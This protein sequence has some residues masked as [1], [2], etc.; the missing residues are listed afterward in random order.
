MVSLQVADQGQDLLLGGDVERGGGLVRD[1]EFR[2]Q[3]QRH[4]DHDALALAA[5][6]PVRI[7]GE[8]ARDLG[9]PD[10]LHHVE[11]ALRWARASRS[12]WAR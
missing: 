6:K 8:D 7:G 2:L 5:R 12:V 4:R 11:D 3:H 10:L 9:Q 1:Q